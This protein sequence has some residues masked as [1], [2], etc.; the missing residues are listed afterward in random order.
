LYLIGLG[1]G[2]ERD[3]TVRGLEI[4]QK[5]DIVYLEYYTSILGVP[6]ETLERFY[7]CTVEIADRNL[8]ENEAEEKLIEPAR[9]QNVVLLVVGDSFGATTHTDLVLRAG[10][11]NVPVEVVH[12]AS[13]MTAI[14]TVGL[15]LYKFGKTTSIPFWEE[16][17]EPK[18]PYDVLLENK[19]RGAHT[20]FLLDIKVKEPSKEELRT[21]I[22]TQTPQP[23]FMTIAQGLEILLRIEKQSKKGLLTPETFVI[24]VARLGQENQKIV[25]GTI[26]ELLSVDFGPPLHSFIVPG[27]LQV[28]EEEA[29][30]RWRT[31]AA[32]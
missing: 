18:T 25:A 9:E 27:D 3:I 20:L 17:Y 26:N 31:K 23:R 29:I 28:V 22:Q 24:G 11:A 15:E 4:V 5:A 16:G 6:R 21:G 13:V 12:N 10:H 8:V 19:A 7:G 2:D 14:G 30:E 32:D 1:L